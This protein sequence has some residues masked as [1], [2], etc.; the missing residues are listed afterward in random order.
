MLQPYRFASAAADNPRATTSTAHTQLATATA[1]KPGSS[2]TPA[3]HARLLVA[4]QPA[5]FTT[6]ASS[7]LF[8]PAASFVAIATRRL[9]PHRPLPCA[10]PAQSRNMRHIKGSCVRMPQQKSSNPPC[11]MS[12]R[13]T[14][15][16]QMV[17]FP[18]VIVIKQKSKQASFLQQDAS[19]WQQQLQS[20]C[21]NLKALCQ[22][23]TPSCKNACGM[24]ILMP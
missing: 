15:L 22:A 2:H 14:R 9:L 24:S 10:S 4:T 18:H 21:G 1:R 23:A 5:G 16:P 11:S 3:H 13:M 19:V 12:N 8:T 17:L 7:S 6:C 20:R